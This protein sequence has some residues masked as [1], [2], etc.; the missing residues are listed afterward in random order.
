MIEAAS[1]PPAPARRI[2]CN[3]TLNMRSI[4]AIGYDMDYT[5]VHYDVEEWERCAYQH[6]R[7]ALIER[8]FPLA[9]QDFD[10]DLVVRGLVA[11]R[12][13]GNLVKCNRFGYAKQAT[14]G[15][16]PLG[17]DEVRKAY[18]RIRIDLRD[19]RF[20]F[21]NTLFSLSESCLWLQAIDLLDR[22][23]LSGV[24]AHG[25][26]SELFATIREATDTAHME[27]KLK[28]AITRDPGRF[29][30]SDPELPLTLLDQKHAGK[31]LL[32]ITNSEWE[33]TRQIME[34]AVGRH[35]PRDVSWRT[36]FDYVIVGARK[37]EFFHGRNPFFEIVDQSG[38]LRP[39]RGPLRPNTCYLG[40]NAAEVERT[41][42]LSGSDFL[43][44]GDHVES[45]INVSKR[46]MS[47]RT[48][49]VL[50]ELEDEVEAVARFRP[51]QRELE[52]LMGR[53]QALE[54]RLAHLRVR[55][56]RA[57]AGYGPEPRE[58]PGALA[59]AQQQ[60]RGEL[61]ALDEEL[62]PLAAASSA[63][64]HARW[65]P[66]MRAGNDKSL[67]ARQVESWADIYTSRVSNFLHATPFVYLR[68][69]RGSLPHDPQAPRE[70]V[71]PGFGSPES[72]E[73]TR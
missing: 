57:K 71:R 54:E 36:L 62:G 16:R 42:G 13:L 52:R 8:G 61:H 23:E 69:P 66:L 35:L 26:Y 58:D 43:Y 38:L 51:R 11:D 40:G 50:R 9:E 31:V 4:A 27:G 1:P 28:S 56:L 46:Q 63:L 21:L 49:L 22:G 18:S 67:L 30:V 44:V 64:G 2:F 70:G 39:V 59:S 3:R 37:P 5:L 73:E 45:D 32:L 25:S 55:A 33:Y 72:E 12:E 17:H 20:W 15:T 47:W 7:A 60:L 48:A 6:T 68:S 53:K 65:G 34:H 19:D 41:L 24:H 14:H 10:P 29:L